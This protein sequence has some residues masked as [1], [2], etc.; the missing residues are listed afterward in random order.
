MRYVIR[1]PNSGRGKYMHDM[2]GKPGP[3]NGCKKF[4]GLQAWHSF[5]KSDPGLVVI[6]RL[7]PVDTPEMAC[8]WHDGLP[9]GSRVN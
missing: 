6:Y 7:V 5:S 3:F 1:L 4:T 9:L 2:T 8:C